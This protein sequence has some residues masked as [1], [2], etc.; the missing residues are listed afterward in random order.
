MMDN[1]PVYKGYLDFSQRLRNLTS[2]GTVW[3]EFWYRES[4]ESSPITGNPH[5]HMT[6]YG[7]GDAVNP[8]SGTVTQQFERTWGVWRKMGFRL[9]APVTQ[10]G[11]ITASIRQLYGAVELDG[12]SI[13]AISDRQVDTL[14]S[15]VEGT[16]SR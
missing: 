7:T 8:A 14:A 12:L 1:F 4:L 10:D 9:R 13:T 2:D 3:V 16:E 11:R 6:L 5:V 15:F